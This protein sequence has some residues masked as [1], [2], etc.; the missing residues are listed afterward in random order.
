MSTKKAFA[1]IVSKENKRDCDNY[2]CGSFGSSRDG[3]TRNHKGVD[4]ISI[5]GETVFSPIS[6]KITRYPYPYPSDFSYTGIEIINDTYKVM[7]F[8][9]SATVSK[10]TQVSAGQ[11]IATAQN[12]AAKYGA[13]MTNHVHVQVYKKSNNTWVLID[14]T[15]LL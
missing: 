9:V 2:G 3:E 15:N 10:G 4:I 6:G 8:Y 1:D 5:P 13:R 11:P 7:L 12:I 14:P